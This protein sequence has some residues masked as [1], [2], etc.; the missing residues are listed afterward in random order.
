MET[1]KQSYLEGQ[2]KIL[3]RLV[4]FADAKYSTVG[5]YTLDGAYGGWELQQYANEH[6]GVS[7]ISKGGHV[8]KRELYNQLG[9]MIEF[10]YSL[11]AVKAKQ[12]VTV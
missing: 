5:A 9:A 1:I 8:S 11:Q 2:V 10:Y 4:G 3:N 12:S 6:G 7:V